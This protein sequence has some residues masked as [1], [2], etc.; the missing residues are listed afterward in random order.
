MRFKKA[1]RLSY[2]YN[3]D[4]EIRTILSLFC[5]LNQSLN[6]DNENKMYL[7]SVYFVEIKVAL[8]TNVS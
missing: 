6:P 1:K 3:S 4:R 8:F 7:L 5:V 2:L